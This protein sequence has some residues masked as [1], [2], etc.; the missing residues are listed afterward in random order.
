MIKPGKLKYSQISN[1]IN[2]VLVVKKVPGS[3]ILEMLEYACAGCPDNY[4]GSFLL[5]S[6]I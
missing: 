2:D 6:G 5:V 3:V 1:L 4:V